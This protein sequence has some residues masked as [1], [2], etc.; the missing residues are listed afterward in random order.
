M[1]WRAVASNTSEACQIHKTSNS[2]PGLGI[3][4]SYDATNLLAVASEATLFTHVGQGHQLKL[5]KQAALNTASLL[6]QTDWS[7]R[8]EMGTA[9]SD[10]F[11]IKVSADGSTWHTA[12]LTDPASGHVTLAHGARIDHLLTGLAVTQSEADTTPGRLLTT[13]SGPSQAFRQGN[14]L[15]NV[16]QVGG[17]PSGA[18]IEHGS[19]ANGNYVRFADGTQICWHIMSSSSVAET[20]WTFPA[21]FALSDFVPSIVTAGTSAVC[22]AISSAST[23]ALGFNIFN[24]SGVR[25]GRLCRLFAIGRWY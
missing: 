23:T 18:A 25:V 2:V 3:N 14:I 11:E 21:M 22:E 6:F 10:A 5:N 19:N 17:V 8:A 16:G 9:G 15:G 13:Q 4:T 12:L 20:T 7:G 1:A 24:T